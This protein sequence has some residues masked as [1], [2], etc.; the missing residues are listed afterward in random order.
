MPIDNKLG[1][2]VTYSERFSPLNP[3][4]PFIT[5]PTWGHCH[6]EK[7]VSPLLGGASACKRFQ[8]A[9]D[10]LFGIGIDNN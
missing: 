8:V 5:R 9:T 1:R 6:F 3:H 4:D 2:V 7:S 10:F